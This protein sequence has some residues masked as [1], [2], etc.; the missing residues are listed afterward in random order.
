QV[1]GDRQAQTEPATLAAAALGETVEDV[2]QQRGVDAL[3]AV[4]HDDADA[5]LTR[6]LD[7]DG[8]GA[9]V[10]GELDRVGQ[11]VPDHLLQAVG[12]TVHRRQGLRAHLELDALRTGRRLHGG[13]RR[14]D[15]RGDVDRS[16]RQPALA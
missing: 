16:K 3:P 1:P 10:R 6:A 5:V 7:G 9:L 11:E 15:D 2:R 4:A 13:E 14:V 8:D 12:V